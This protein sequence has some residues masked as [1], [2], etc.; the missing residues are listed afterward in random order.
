MRTAVDPFYFSFALSWSRLSASGLFCH[1][2][3]VTIFP[4]C[5]PMTQIVYFLAGELEIG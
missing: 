4:I 5:V 2:R 3:A 1:P